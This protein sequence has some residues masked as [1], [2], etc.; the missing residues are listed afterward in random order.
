MS[1]EIETVNR[2]ALKRNPDDSPVQVTFRAQAAAERVLVTNGLS[3]VRARGI[4][5]LLIID[6]R[7]HETGKG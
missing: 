4:A 7:L 1:R 2:R 3:R 5:N 6:E